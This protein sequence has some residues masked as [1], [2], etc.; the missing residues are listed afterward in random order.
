M[1]SYLHKIFGKSELNEFD[2][3]TPIALAAHILAFDVVLKKIIYKYIMYN[4]NDKLINIY[5]N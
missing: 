1:A 2:R 5:T 3:G 4:S